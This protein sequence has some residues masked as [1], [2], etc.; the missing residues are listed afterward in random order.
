[1]DVNHEKQENSLKIIINTSWL[2]FLAKVIH[3]HFGIEG[4]TKAVYTITV[5]QVTVGGTSE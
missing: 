3:K 5:T 1:M 4:F 2:T